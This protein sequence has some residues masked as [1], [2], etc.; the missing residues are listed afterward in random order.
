MIGAADVLCPGR[1]YME[2]E[3]VTNSYKKE[4]MN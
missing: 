3:R 2:K 4:K 1:D